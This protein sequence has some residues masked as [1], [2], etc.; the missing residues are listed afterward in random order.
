MSVIRHSSLRRID[1]MCRIDLSL[2]FH[3]SEVAE[4]PCI[5]N[6]CAGCN[7]ASPRGR[8]SAGRGGEEMQFLNVS[9]IYRIYLLTTDHAIMR[10]GDAL[11]RSEAP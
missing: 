10:R 2:E 11:T 9:F 3:E 1:Q 6:L 5:R 8:I 4:T 7:F